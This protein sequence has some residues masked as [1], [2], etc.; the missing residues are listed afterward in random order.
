MTSWGKITDIAGHMVLP[1]I[2]LTLITYA[3][4]SRY[5]RGSMLD[6]LNSDYIR[7]ARAK[8]LRARQVM[9][10]HALRTALIPLTTV[11][12]IDIAGILGGAI[13]TETVF[14][15]GGMGRYLITSVYLRDVNAVLGWLLVS[16]AI[17]IVF[18]IIADLLYAVR[19]PSIRYE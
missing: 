1:T 18:N 19:D 11:T 15:W 10:R 7:L 4:W 17:V 8:G 2:S 9:V 5:Q 16:G 13:V 3:G 14:N 12:A 6:V